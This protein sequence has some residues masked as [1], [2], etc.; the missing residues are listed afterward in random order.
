MLEQTYSPS[1]V[2]KLDEGVEWLEKKMFKMAPCEGNNEKEMNRLSN[3]NVEQSEAHGRCSI[4]SSLCPCYLVWEVKSGLTNGLKHSLVLWRVLLWAWHSWA[5]RQKAAPAL[6][7][8][9]EQEARL[10]EMRSCLPGAAL[11]ARVGYVTWK[12]IMQDFNVTISLLF[13]NGWIF[14]PNKYTE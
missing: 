5:E 8:G 13:K 2:L 12:K 14:K 10:G 1:L 4:N 7:P 11:S 3:I 9:L 6:Q